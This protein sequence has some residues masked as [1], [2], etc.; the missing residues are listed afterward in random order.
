MGRVRVVVIGAGIV[1]LMTAVEL[2]ARGAEVVVVDEKPSLGLEAS[3]GNAGVLHVVQLPF[4]SYKSRLLR[5]SRPRLRWI[6]R[7]LGVPV[8]SNVLYIHFSGLLGVLDWFA[9]RITCLYLRLVGRLPCRTVRLQ[10]G[11][12]VAVVE[13]Y[14][15][16]N[17]YRLL[18]ALAKA[19]EKGG[20]ILVLGRRVEEIVFRNGRAAGV[21]LDGGVVV[22]ADI[23][24]NAAGSGAQSLALR[25]G[26]K[27][28]RQRL[29]KGV[30]LLAASSSPPRALHGLVG[31]KKS[32]HTK[33]G[34]VIPFSPTAVLVGPNLA[35]T[36][37]PSDTTCERRAL[38]ELIARFSGFL[39]NL[40]PLYCYGGVRVI[41]WPEDDFIIED[42]GNGLINLYGIDSPGFTDSAGLALQVASIAENYG[43]S[44]KP[45]Y[46][47]LSRVFD[48]REY[49]SPGSPSLCPFLPWQP[50]VAGLA[51][52]LSYTQ[53][54]LLQALWVSGSPWCLSSGTGYAVLLYHLDKEK[55]KT[56]N[57]TFN[58]YVSLAEKIQPARTPKPV[59]REN[60][61]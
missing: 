36:T 48:P 14:G 18:Y 40:K 37:S 30:M 55:N 10:R 1:G 21:R 35:F 20:G 38:K 23:V 53:D 60:I 11:G 58:G 25:A 44:A 15:V 46:D 16:V 6:A 13:G 29:G 7:R 45:S 5:K 49:F 61:G 50:G 34:G 54:S 51:R 4:R 47:L 9:A 22:E 26:C 52:A 24:V 43:V 32:K 2:L 42:C 12:R 41:N 57:I 19:V 31:G 8:S 56:I 17:Q 28:P 33:G 59:S 39:D 3:G 27:A